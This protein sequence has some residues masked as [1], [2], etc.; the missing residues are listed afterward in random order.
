MDYAR[1]FAPYR[2]FVLSVCL[3]DAFLPNDFNIIALFDE[4]PSNQKTFAR[5]IANEND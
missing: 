3:K 5:D 1:L 2:F 4:F